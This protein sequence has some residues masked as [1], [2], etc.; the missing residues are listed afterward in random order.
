MIV[1]VFDT[2]LDSGEFLVKPRNGRRASDNPSRMNIP[3]SGID[4]HLGGKL[5][6]FAVNR[7]AHHDGYMALAVRSRTLDVEKNP[8]RVSH[9]F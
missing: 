7:N 1:A 6:S 9:T 2:A 5:S 8:E 3:Y 4:T